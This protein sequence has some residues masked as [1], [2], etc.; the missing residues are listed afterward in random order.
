MTAILFDA[1]RPVKSRKL[2]GIGILAWHPI[3]REHYTQADLDWAAEVFGNAEA[4]RRL[5]EQARQARW[6][7]QF[8]GAF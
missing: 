2:F 5:E 1:T 6:D 3:H 4:D 8:D 7:A